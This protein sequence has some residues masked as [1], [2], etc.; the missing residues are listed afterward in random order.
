MR[1][2]CSGKTFYKL[3][4]IGKVDAYRGKY[5]WLCL[6]E[7]GNQIICLGSY[8]KK[9]YQKSCGC[10]RKPNDIKETA[11]QRFWKFVNKTE[12]CWLWIGSKTQ[13]YAY[14]QIS[15]G[16]V[17]IR[18]NRFSWTLHYGDIPK[19]LMVCHRCDNPS[20]VNPE[21]LFLGDQKANMKDMVEK[22]RNHIRRGV[23]T[24]ACKLDDE[25]VKTIRLLYQEPWSASELAGEFGVSKQNILD[26]VNRK[27]WKHVP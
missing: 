11:E 1:N 14:G 2:D 4:V 15:V 21:H 3:K 18:A 25:K 13:G 12:T 22:K 5:R 23:D 19:G 16:G 26:I 20:C 17:P 9:G 27:A 7:C 6:C 10:W 24:T 8:L